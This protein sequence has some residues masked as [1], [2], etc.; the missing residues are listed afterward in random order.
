[1]ATKELQAEIFRH[2]LAKEEVTRARLALQTVKTTAQYDGKRRE[3]ELANTLARWQKV[4]ASPGS[5]ASIT[6]NPHDVIGRNDTNPKGRDPLSEV[7][8]L[9]QSLRELEQA[10]VMVQDENIQLREIIAD[11]ASEVKSTFL[12]IS[13][14]PAANTNEIE[15]DVSSVAIPWLKSEP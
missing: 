7:T 3:N 10:R 5:T 4:S 15:D 8:L 11:V 1:M 13:S 14:K 9:E 12:A 6:L 2:S